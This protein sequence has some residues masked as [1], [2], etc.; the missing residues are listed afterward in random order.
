ML[1]TMYQYSSPTDTKNFCYYCISLKYWYSNDTAFMFI[2]CRNKN[3]H[4]RICTNLSWEWL[5]AVRTV[6]TL[7]EML[8]DLWSSLE[9]HLAKGTHIQGGLL[10]L[11]LL[12]LAASHVLSVINYIHVHVRILL[13]SSTVF[14]NFIFKKLGK[15]IIYRDLQKSLKKNIDTVY[16]ELI[17]PQI[18]RFHK[19][20]VAGGT[21]IKL[22]ISCLLPI[23]L[24]T[25]PIQSLRGVGL[26]S[27]WDILLQC[28]I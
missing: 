24:T 2:D 17:L 21:F 10:H 6:I 13:S 27:H 26:I 3:Q 20:A 23:I 7:E 8:R 1:K 25:I 5:L 18:Q 11:C 14:W 19:L 15:Y 16:S 9:G 4:S 12:L 22:L 28:T